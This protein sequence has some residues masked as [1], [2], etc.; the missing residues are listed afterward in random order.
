MSP[1]Q[2]LSE[3]LDARSDV[4]SLGIVLWEL[5][6]SRRLFK[7][8]SQ[9][10]TFDAITKEPIPLPASLSQE[11]NPAIE[12]VI[13]RALARHRDERFASA[14]DLQDGLEKAMGK[15]GITGTP[16]TLARFLEQHFADEREEQ[17]KLLV[18]ARKGEVS[19]TDPSV[20][21]FPGEDSVDVEQPTTDP[22]GE[23]LPPTEADAPET[24]VDPD[25]LARL[26]PPEHFDSE[27]QRA[28]IVRPRRQEETRQSLMPVQ[29]PPEPP[30]AP[31]T[32]P[33]RKLNNMSSAYWVVV[34]LMAITI[35]LLV[36]WA[37]L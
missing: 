11:V 28:T 4:F 13:M 1:E 21:A 22:E 29:S 20:V 27:T 6:T 24:V 25:P 7:R 26:S 5:C 17:Q 36:L 12:A 37:V 34:G 19:K 35:L 2:C 8:P 23:A 9:Q 30:P 18:L 32:G 16:S 33:S 31:D 10:A 15:A 14:A 3:P